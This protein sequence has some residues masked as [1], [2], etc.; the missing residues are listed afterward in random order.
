MIAGWCERQTLACLSHQSG[1]VSFNAGLCNVTL[2]LSIWR[3]VHLWG[4]AERPA[5]AKCAYTDFSQTLVF[6]QESV[7]HLRSVSN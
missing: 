6:I 2:W 4:G 1:L 5:N 3:W 7:Q